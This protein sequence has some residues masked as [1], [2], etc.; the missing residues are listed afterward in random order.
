MHD[1]YDFKTNVSVM[2]NLTEVHI[3]HF[4]TY[5]FYKEMKARIFN[6]HTE[7]DTAIYN[8]ANEDVVDKV[9]DILSNKISFTAMDGYNSDLYLKDDAIYYHDELIIKTK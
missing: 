3:D 6:R 9:K 8:I 1:C 5:E 2:T 4:K 7:E